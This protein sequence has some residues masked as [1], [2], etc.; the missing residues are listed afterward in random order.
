MH[1][2]PT[3]PAAGEA[4]LAEAADAK[5][6][7]VSDALLLLLVHLAFGLLLNLLGRVGRGAGNLFLLTLVRVLLLQ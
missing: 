6:L 3:E 2:L 1:L 5:L 7:Q 4:L